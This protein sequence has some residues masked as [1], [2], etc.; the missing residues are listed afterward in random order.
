[1]KISALCL[2]SFAICFE[3]NQRNSYLGPLCFSATTFAQNINIKIIIQQRTDSLP[4]TLPQGHIAEFNLIL[5]VINLPKFCK[6][7]LMIGHEGIIKCSHS[8]LSYIPE[9]INLLFCI[10]CIRYINHATA[11]RNSLD[12]SVIQPTFTRFADHCIDL[13][14]RTFKTKF[15][16]QS[17]RSYSQLQLH[18]SNLLIAIRL[19]RSGRTE[20]GETWGRGPSKNVARKKIGRRERLW[21]NCPPTYRLPTETCNMTIDLWIFNF[22]CACYIVR[23][24]HAHHKIKKNYNFKVII[25][26]AISLFST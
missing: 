23:C 24:S 20:R 12:C 6:Y 13:V 17:P 2:N 3:N 10:P 11:F 4:I 8:G 7:R 22:Y 26:I 25:L 14:C 15:T 18:A 1:M 19:S 5:V 16:Y 9:C 21:A